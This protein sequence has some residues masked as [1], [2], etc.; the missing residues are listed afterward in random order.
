MSQVWSGPPD[1]LR[2][3]IYVRGPEQI[4]YLR[5]NGFIRWYKKDRR[6]PNRYTINVS[7]DKWTEVRR[8]L[9]AQNKIIKASRG[10]QANGR[11]V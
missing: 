7:K 10:E 11:D 8:I 6:W 4:K 9:H 2:R 5:D 3:K 1:I